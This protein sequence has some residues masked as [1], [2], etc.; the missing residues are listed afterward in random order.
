MLVRENSMIR[1]TGRLRVAALITAVLALSA[2]GSR[3][4]GEEILAGAGGGTVTLDPASVAELKSVTAGSAAAPAAAAAA[5]SGTVPAAASSGTVPA[6]ASSGTVPAAGV[7]T[8]TTAQ[9]PP[10]TGKTKPGKKTN[11]AVTAQSAPAAATAASAP[12]TASGTPVKLGQIGAFSGVA[13]PI[14]ASARTALATWVQ[15]VNS[16]GGLACHPVVLYALDD[17]ADPAKAAAQVQELQNKGVQALVA[18]FDP[19]GFAGLRS[20]VEKA[21]MPVIGGDGIDFGWNESPYLFP[22]GAGLLGAVRGAIHQTVA[23]GKTNLGLLY[24]V[25]AS[26]CTNGAK[27]I[28]PEVEKAGAKMTYESAISLTQTD[29]TAQCQSAKNAG[30]QALGMAMDGASIGRVARSCAAINYHPQFV[31]NGLVLSP[32]NALDPDIR[33]NTLSSSSAVAPWML[34]DTPGQRE[35]QAA[36]KKYAPSLVPDANSIYAWTSGKLVEAA[37]D[38]LGAAARSKPL[39]TAEIMAGLGT[40]KKN[41]LGG[42][43][44]PI[45]FTAGQAK[46]P[47]IN[48]VYYEL[49]SDKG[50]TATSSKPFCL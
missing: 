10:T 24:C 48:C 44:P 19:L 47:L 42:L 1:R 49:L 29:F 16:R 13:G 21:K 33:K 3:V 23:S 35:Y 34:S 14:T 7:A 26:A 37:V 46:A 12:C 43:T 41:N 32:Q 20:G 45:T 36:L 2:C 30:V 31:T 25:E 6:A 9:A 22:V 11:A 4:S 50:W 18:V 17:G 15:D 5:S 8:G 38:G 28:P 40:V 27:I 39:T